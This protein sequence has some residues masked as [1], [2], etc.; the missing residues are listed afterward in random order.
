MVEKK[1]PSEYLSQDCWER[2]HREKYV[3]NHKPRHYLLHYG[4]SPFTKV[5]KWIESEKDEVKGRPVPSLVWMF[6]SSVCLT[7]KSIRHFFTYHCKI[8][9]KQLGNASFWIFFYFF[10]MPA[11]TRNGVRHII[12]HRSSWS[13]KSVREM[14]VHFG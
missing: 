14:P 9:Y 6:L 5:F 3:W 12:R 13:Y 1:T 4:N 10:I 11:S 2:I 8:L 7:C